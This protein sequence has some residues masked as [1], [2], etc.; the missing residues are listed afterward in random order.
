LRFVQ[1][2]HDT[3]DILSVVITGLKK[4]YHSEF[5]Y[6]KAGVVLLDLICADRQQK[7]LFKLQEGAVAKGRL[8][9][10]MDRLNRR[11]GKDKVYFAACG[12]QKTLTCSQN[13]SP[14]YTTRWEDILKV[15]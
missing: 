6:K 8:M 3:Q 9:E 12:L 4:I 15:R 14:A 11:Y 7:D 13:V 5:R 2:T 10:T 1:A